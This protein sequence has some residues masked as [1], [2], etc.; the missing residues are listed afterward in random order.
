MKMI[1]LKA[2]AKI[3]LGL[4]ILSQR[5]DGYHNIETVFHRVQPYDEIRLEPSSDITLTVNSPDLPPDDNNLCVKAATL[6]QQYVGTENGVHIFLNKNIPIGAG[7]GGGSAD[8][9]ATL[10][11]LMNLWH[12]DIPKNELLKIGL[13]LGSDVSYFLSLGTAY[14]TSR[15]EILEYFEFSM[16]YWIVIIYPNIHVS[17]KWA[18]EAIHDI[19]YKKHESNVNNPGLNISLR[20][21]LLDHVHD[22]IQ[23]N[24]VLHNDFEPIVLHK[25]ETIAFAKVS[26]YAAGAKFA[27]MSG[28]GSAI[29]GLFSSE[30]DAIEAAGQFRKRY[31]VFMTPPN[32]KPEEIILTV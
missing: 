11:G 6:L 4:R 2:Y 30:Q 17:T 21:I 3:N 32:F 19:R 29:Y 14:A 9:A 26:L 31:Q 8:A 20:Q 15:G 27:Q 24:A 7:L 22:P 16:P 28:S 5:D 10:I 23:L 18:Y 12:I 1:N 25:Y 13:Q